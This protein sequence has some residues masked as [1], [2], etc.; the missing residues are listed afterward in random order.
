MSV[1]V[2]M[3]KDKGDKTVSPMEFSKP[4][5]VDSRSR[6]QEMSQYP[7]TYK[8]KN[9]GNGKRADHLCNTG[10]NTTFYH[11]NDGYNKG[12]EVECPSYEAK[13]RYRY[14]KKDPRNKKTA[15]SCFYRRPLWICEICSPVTCIHEIFTLNFSGHETQYT[16]G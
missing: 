9:R 5:A 6:E 1:T 2:T 11:H 15:P 12:S 4:Q 14:N 13:S 8:I 10:A 7:K 3:R 16:L